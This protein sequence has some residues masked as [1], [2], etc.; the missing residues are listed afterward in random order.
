VAS[1]KEEKSKE[2]GDLDF[3]THC[4]RFKSRLLALFHLA[5]FGDCLGYELF[6]F[7]TF[8]K[9]FFVINGYA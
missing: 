6:I 9:A 2:E 8:L 7:M 5:F 1:G 3:I 4:F